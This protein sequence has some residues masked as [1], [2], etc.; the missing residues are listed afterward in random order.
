MIVDALTCASNLTRFPRN[1]FRH[2]QATQ[3]SGGFG[4]TTITKS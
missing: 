2:G 3:G 4:P 1:G